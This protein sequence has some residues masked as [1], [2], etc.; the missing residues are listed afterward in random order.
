MKVQ[1][2]QPPTISKT[3]EVQLTSLK[4]EVVDKTGNI[5]SR[6]ELIDFLKR[7]GI[8]VGNSISKLTIESDRVI[9][10]TDKGETQEIKL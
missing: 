8:R 7:V 9:M 10:E 5:N 2:V 3:R 6:K 4:L 1:P